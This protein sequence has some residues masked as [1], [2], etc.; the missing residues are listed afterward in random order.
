VRVETNPLSPIPKALS[1]G[2]VVVF[3]YVLIGTMPNRYKLVAR[4]YG[5]NRAPLAPEVTLVP[6]ISATKYVDFTPTL[7]GG[8]FM[9]R[10]IQQGSVFT[11]SVRRLNANLATVAPDYTFAGQSGDY[12]RI[13]ALSSNRAVVLY[14]N[15]VSGRHRLLAQIVSY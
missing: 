10:A 13:A 7:D 11:R 14:R 6:D 3:R 8:L 2:R 4:L 12:F 5:S 15:V 9:I 1:N